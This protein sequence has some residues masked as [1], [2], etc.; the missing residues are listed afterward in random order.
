MARVIHSPADSFLLYFID[1]LS[2]L[3]RF[4]LQ[5]KSFTFEVFQST[6]IKKSSLENHVYALGNNI[7]ALKLFI[8]VS[9][10]YHTRFQ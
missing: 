5:A 6:V 7:S 8:L 2:H 9:K 1:I 10:S 4:T 3:L